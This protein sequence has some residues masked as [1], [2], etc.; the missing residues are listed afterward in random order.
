MAIT[1]LTELRTAVSDRLSRVDLTSTVLD[2]CVVLAEA[3]MQ[4]ELDT[5]DQETTNA[6]YS[7]TGEFVAVPTGCDMVRSFHLNRAE[8]WPL[9]QMPSDLQNF[10]ATDIP[11]YFERVGGNFR[12]APIPNATYTATIV[13]VARFTP[14]TSSANWLLTAHPDAY[15]YGTLKHAC[16]KTQDTAGIGQ[17]DGEFQKIIARINRR[18]RKARWSG[19]G[20]QIRPA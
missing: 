7:I 18:S 11:M 5:L 10:P 3:D 13:Y 16:V 8:P 15:L 9:R 12:F 2:E 20:L 1:T 19:P 6:S 17:F 14:L 4:R